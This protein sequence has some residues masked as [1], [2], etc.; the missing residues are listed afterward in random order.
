VFICVNVCFFCC[1]C[2][3]SS[4]FGEVLLWNWESEQKEPVLRLRP[5]DGGITC[6]DAAPGGWVFCTGGNDRR[7]AMIDVRNICFV[8]KE[9]NIQ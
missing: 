6:V 1:C 8:E 7:V 4:A 2:F 9:K 3:Q 5:H